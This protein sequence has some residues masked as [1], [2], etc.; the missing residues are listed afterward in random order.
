VLPLAIR[1][2]EASRSGGREAAAALAWNLLQ[3][4]ASSPPGLAQSLLGWVQEEGD[5]EDADAGAGLSVYVGA[6]MLG[7]L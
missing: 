2:M 3:T 5:G 4:G 1:I 6:K 7:I